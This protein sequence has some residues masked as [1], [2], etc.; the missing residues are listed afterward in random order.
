MDYENYK[1]KKKEYAER[2]KKFE[3]E[4]LMKSTGRG[5]TE[6]RSTTP[7]MSMGIDIFSQMEP[8]VKEEE[9]NF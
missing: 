3:Y 7:E 9:E 5:L 6:E 2:K 4:N 1:S 8:I